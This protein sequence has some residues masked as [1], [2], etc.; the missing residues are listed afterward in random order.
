V[1]PRA[2]DQGATWHILSA[3]RDVVLPR[4]PCPVSTFIQSQSQPAGSRK[5]VQIVHKSVS[6]AEEQQPQ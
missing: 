1:N 2:V 4:A 5:T 6:F 3:R